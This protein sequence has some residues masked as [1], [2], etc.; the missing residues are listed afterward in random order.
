MKAA[1]E[2]STS[3]PVRPL[4]D[5]ALS[6]RV[7]SL[8]ERH[9]TS[10]VPTR[11]TSNRELCSSGSDDTRTKFA[12]Q[13]H[14]A[15]IPSLDR[16][17]QT[18]MNLQGREYLHSSLTSPI[19]PFREL[20]NPNLCPSGHSRATVL[21][22]DQEHP[23]SI[24]AS[25]QKA[26]TLLNREGQEF[27]HSNMT[28]LP[29]KPLRE[30]SNPNLCPSGHSRAT[31]L[32]ED[33]ENPTTIPA[34]DRKN[35]T[36]QS[37]EGMEFLH[38]SNKCPMQPVR[39]P[40][41]HCHSVCQPDDVFVD[42]AHTANEPSMSLSN[43]RQPL[44]MA[45]VHSIP[46]LGSLRT[47]PSTGY[48]TEISEEDDE[49]LSEEETEPCLHYRDIRLDRPLLS[50]LP[51][52]HTDANSLESDNGDD[53]SNICASEVAALKKHWADL[54]KRIDAMTTAQLPHDA[55]AF[56]IGGSMANLLERI[57]AMESQLGLVASVSHERTSRKMSSSIRITDKRPSLGSPQPEKSTSRSAS[58][59]R[60]ST[61]RSQLMRGS[62]SSET[63]TTKSNESRSKSVDAVKRSTQAS[64]PRR[65]R[66]NSFEKP[67]SKSV[68]RKPR[69]KPGQK[70]EREST[71]D[72]TG[73]AHCDSPHA[74]GDVS[75]ANLSRCSIVN[76][77]DNSGGSNSRRLQ[78]QNR[79]NSRDASTVM[80]E[81]GSSEATTTKSNAHRSKSM[82]VVNRLVTRSTLKSVSGK[83]RSK[84]RQ[85]QEGESIHNGT[86]S[87]HC[88][89][90]HPAVNSTGASSS[91][92]S[93][94]M[95]DSSG[96][97]S[98]RRSMI[99]KEISGASSS[100]RS[101][102]KK[103]SSGGSSSSRL[104]AKTTVKLENGTSRRLS[105]GRPRAR[106]K[107][108]HFDGH[109]SESDVTGQRAL[110]IKGRPGQPM[111]AA[112]KA[113]TKPSPIT[114]KGHRLKSSPGGR[115]RLSQS[116]RTLSVPHFGKEAQGRMPA[117]GD[118]ESGN[119]A[120]EDCCE[121]HIGHQ[122]L[123]PVACRVVRSRSVKGLV[124]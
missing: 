109:K 33:Q 67:A 43:S 81:L 103:D 118:L 50:P 122:S 105:S 19:P 99:V 86:G 28:C 49:I 11:A 107:N 94:T 51:L 119:K 15:S 65:C 112:L 100:R 31:V 24:P 21:L 95:K 89:P 5:Q 48:S 40:S 106:A 71:Q 101:V 104:Q 115:H 110:K 39:E 13:D 17:M 68:S 111:D 62:C 32:L 46:S 30:P 45:S 6:P 73:S 66:S 55:A 54:G 23:T 80:L 26:Q 102:T 113:L 79:R 120:D 41:S 9:E 22:E 124:F 7:L 91:R 88:S 10:P 56:V 108:V 121:S 70:G 53:C 8:I 90:P 93:V 14:P 78:A 58:T 83:P 47:I 92:R 25:E 1:Q 57:E 84:P 27:M 76:I 98:S 44:R 60:T 117:V 42:S 123:A 37:R 16:K 18:L 36:L 34:A 2:R 69:S 38:S 64:R 35:L 61:R 20:S 75:D 59:A 82:D 4:K 85:N 74:T 72:G 3:T 96:A 12:Q 63:T 77:K 29:I 87:T 97:S 116:A 114:S 52:K